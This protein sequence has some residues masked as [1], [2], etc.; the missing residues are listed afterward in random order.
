MG[1]LARFSFHLPDIFFLD[2]PVVG[3]NESKK[4]EEILWPLLRHDVCM[5]R[6]YHLV[7]LECLG[8]RRPHGI[9]CQ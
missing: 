4:Q 1:I 7:D 9:S 6:N 3:R 8:D 5:E 2:T